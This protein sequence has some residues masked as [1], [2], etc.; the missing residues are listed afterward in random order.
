DFHTAL[1]LLMMAYGVNTLDEAVGQG[2]ITAEEHLDFVDGLD[3]LWRL[4]NELHFQSNK[5]EDRLTFA[6]Q[7]PVATAFGYARPHYLLQSYYTAAG[8][9]RRFLRIAARTCV[10]AGSATFPDAGMP[11]AQEYAIENGELYVG[12]GDPNWFGHNPA[13]LMEVFWLCARHMVPLSRSSE[14]LVAESL[15]LV[16]DTF[17]GNNIVRRFFTAIC[18]RPYQAGH[19]FRQASSCGLLGRYLPEFAAVQ[20][21]IR[22]EDFHSYPV[23][24]HTLRALEAI[25]R[26]ND[27]E[28][29]IGRCLQEALENLSDPYILIMAILFHDL[30][31]V[32]GEVHIDA[33]VRIT[34]EIC[35]RMGMTGDD[36][37]RIAFL[38]QHHSLMTII[39]QYRDIDDEFIVRNFAETMKTELRL[40]ALFLISYADL[41]AVG[42]AVW[43]EW[44]GALLLQLYLRT[45]KRMLG[46]AET[47][48]EEFWTTQKAQE[49]IEC[50]RDDLKDKVIEHLQGL[51]QRYFV[52]FEAEKI[53][54]HL[55]CV[56][57][58]RKTGLD[59]RA[60]SNPVTGM[61]EV[62]ICTRDCH[63]LFAK[64]A[65]CFSSQLVDINS[66]ALFTRPDGIVVDVFMVCDARR[67][68]PLTPAQ[69]AKVAQVLHAVLLEGEDVQEHVERALRRLF[70][71]LQPRI[72][73]PT[74]VEFDNGSSRRRTIIDIETGDRTGLLYD[75]TRA[76]S[77]LGLDIAT[78]RI[79]TDARRVRDSFYVTQNKQKIEDPEMLT[80]IRE[81]IHQAIHP[82]AAADT[83]GE[84]Q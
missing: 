62:V 6:L 58:A 66:A 47:A 76:I 27:V 55:E 39:S 5:A 16:T 48:G 41:S 25:G 71:L 60:T 63:G 1:W 67:M 19:A 9:L 2:I 26:I 20:E 68:Q 82:R 23:G 8:K 4:R 29:A 18:N 65:G 11:V 77:E 43:N 31:K 12:A 73:I 78:A 72:P 52:A 80:A 61:S 49:V 13:R 17:R 46:R 24:E 83:K 36:E 74:R 32:E 21:V 44:K 59:I 70:A 42:P 64:I 54:M 15:H 75:I 38:V 81:G 22:Y 28:G 53:A 69:T 79:V 50:V 10:G 34:R 40:R 57:E 3:F 45:M 30:G 84:R 7:I 35:S 56:E 33:S 51:S 37:E 14:L